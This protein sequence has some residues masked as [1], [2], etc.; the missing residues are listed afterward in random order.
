MLKCMDREKFQND[1]YSLGA[2]IVDC[3]E[4]GTALQNGEVLTFDWDNVLDEFQKLTKT[5]TAKELLE[6]RKNV[7][8]C[9]SANTASA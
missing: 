3:L 5:K 7:V 1:I 6:V 9:D 8:F 2:I 4:P